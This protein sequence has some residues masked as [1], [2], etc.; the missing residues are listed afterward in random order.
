[1]AVTIK[2]TQATPEP[3]VNDAVTTVPALS[4]PF[5]DPATETERLVHRLNSE[6]FPVELYGR[7]DDILTY[8]LLKKKSW[9]SKADKTF[10]PQ[11]VFPAERPTNR[12]MQQ[13]FPTIQPIFDFDPLNAEEKGMA[14]G[15]LLSKDHAEMFP[16]DSRR[17]IEQ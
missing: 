14:L 13:L 11:R 16:P 3:A 17:C 4:Y 7:V 6:T 1:M 12:V 10:Q 2:P 15:R 9:K 8:S 5:T